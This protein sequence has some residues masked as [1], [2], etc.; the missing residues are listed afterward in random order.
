MW[1]IRSW[2]VQPERSRSRC[3]PS[4]DPPDLR[5]DV[6]ELGSVYLGGLTFSQL[7]RAGLVEGSPDALATADLMFGWTIAPWCPEVF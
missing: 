2:G 3:E 5:L 6:R 1:R 4:T 7:A